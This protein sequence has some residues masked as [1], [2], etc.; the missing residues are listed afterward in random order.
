MQFFPIMM[1]NL[2]KYGKFVKM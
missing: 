2:R 1:H